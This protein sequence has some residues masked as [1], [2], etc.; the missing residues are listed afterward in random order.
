MEYILPKKHAEN[1]EMKMPFS[2]LFKKSPKKELD[3]KPQ[4][5]EMNRGQTQMPFHHQNSRP[6]SESSQ[7]T[8]PMSD[9]LKSIAQNSMDGNGERL[10][11]GEGMTPMTETLQNGGKY[12]LVHP[13]VIRKLEQNGIDSFLIYETGLR[14][15][16][17]AGIPQ[18][19][20]VGRNVDELLKEARGKPE[21]QL[22][23]HVRQLLWLKDNAANYGYTHTGNSWILK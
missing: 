9:L 1:S 10:V 14:S 15:E 8:E 23:A 20:F 2:S 5:S 16:L 13:E 3:S 17:A 12:I 22:P 4:L 21:R 18:I 6:S 7:K 19:D 11:L